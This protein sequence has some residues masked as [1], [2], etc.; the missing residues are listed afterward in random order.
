MA[1]K[2]LPDRVNWLLAVIVSAERA[3]AERRHGEARA[4]LKRAIELTKT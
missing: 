2:V 4:I 1:G 3:L